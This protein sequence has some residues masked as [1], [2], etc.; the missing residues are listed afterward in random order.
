MDIFTYFRYKNIISLIIVSVVSFYILRF[1]DASVDTFYP[2]LKSEISIKDIKKDD[3]IKLLIQ[4]ML[5]ILIYMVFV[6]CCF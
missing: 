2:V 6:T 5:F 4:I 1:I 3:L